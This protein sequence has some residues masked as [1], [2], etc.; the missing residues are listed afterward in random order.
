M[1]SGSSPGQFPCTLSC[2][3]I[4]PRK[5]EKKMKVL[6]KSWFMMQQEKKQATIGIS[7]LYNTQKLTFL[8]INRKNMSEFTQWEK[9]G[10]RLMG[11]V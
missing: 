5:K 1:T 8:F 6:R 4:E 9:L 11:T 3:S 7:I 10:I 2:F